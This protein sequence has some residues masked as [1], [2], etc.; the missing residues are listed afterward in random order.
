MAKPDMDNVDHLIQSERAKYQAP[1]ERAKWLMQLF[2]VG[3][4]TL[5]FGAGIWVVLGMFSSLTPEGRVVFTLLLVGGSLAI[6]FVRRF[7]QNSRLASSLTS[8]IG[9]MVLGYSLFLVLRQYGGI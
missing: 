6:Y 3:L 5:I 7:L 9:M 8:V 4:L 1:R 2:G